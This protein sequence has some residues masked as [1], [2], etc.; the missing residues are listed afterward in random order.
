MRHT[1][2]RLGSGV[3]LLEPTASSFFPALLLPVGQKLLI[4]LVG[5]KT[6]S[7]CRL[8]DHRDQPSPILLSKDLSKQANITEPGA[9]CPAI[10]CQDVQSYLTPER[11]LSQNFCWLSVEPDTGKQYA[12]SNP[13]CLHGFADTLS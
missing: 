1:L 8:G 12:V 3:E 11:V 10:R 5:Q 7:L 6:Q 9:P 13:E 2:D 4:R